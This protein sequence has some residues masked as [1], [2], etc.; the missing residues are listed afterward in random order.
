MSD[1]PGPGGPGNHHKDEIKAMLERAKRVVERL[2][3]KS[4]DTRL[5]KIDEIEKTA[6][7]H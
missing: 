5:R 7:R 2:V 3:G 6:A 4:K 1:P